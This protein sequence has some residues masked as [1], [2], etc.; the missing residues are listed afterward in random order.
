MDLEF[1]RPLLKY[2]PEVE[3]PKKRVPLKD[4]LIWTGVILIIFFVMGLVRPYGLETG[5]LPAVFE[6]MQVIFAS[7]MGSIISL[8]IGPIV[9]ASIVLQLM[10]G[11]KM[12][13]IDLTKNEGKAL[14]Q[15]TQKLL[16]IIV[17]FFETTALVYGLG[18]V[19]ES[20]FAL[21]IIFQIALG[22]I[23]LMFMDEVVSKWGIGSGIGLFIAAGVSQEVVTR[24]IN[25]LPT[26]GGGFAGLI[27]T[28]L[29]NLADGHFNLILLFP[30]LATIIV[31]L[32]VAYGESMRL[33]IPVSY[34][35]ISR[36]GT[37][38]PLK[39][40]YVSVIPVILAA[41]VLANVTLFAGVFGI[42][43]PNTGSLYLPYDASIVQT[44]VYHVSNSITLGELRGIL[45]PD[46]IT[47]IFDPMILI[48]AL[49]Y[50]TV[51]VGLCI[52]FG[53][54]WVETTNIGSENV[55]E[56]IHRTG[57]QIPGYRKDKRIVKKVLDKYIPQ[58][59]IISS[60]AIGLLAVGS[61]LIG[62]LSSGTGILL[63]VGI[64]YRLYEELQREQMAEMHPSLRRFLGQ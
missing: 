34:G 57:M 42:T 48:H 62:T 59:T 56:Q 49:I 47:R 35:N 50:T 11:T 5:A 44:V 14:F 46:Q 54:F 25:I 23:L 12:I 9:T 18:M 58:I 32:V 7:Q 2:I 60:I 38:H 19:S 21:F 8:G 63:T 4:K 39:F 55:A 28:F 36:F 3:I 6:Q 40:F 20:S 37:K 29:Q 31:F 33:E 22:S 15:G 16:V 53:K 43:D 26:G 30:I 24:I 17:S 51:F 41:A 61:D 27:P 10:V 52:V 13:D 1:V 45:S 64:L